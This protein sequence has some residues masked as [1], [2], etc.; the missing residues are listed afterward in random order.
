MEIQEKAKQS[1]FYITLLI[2]SLIA[3]VFWL[4]YILQPFFAGLSLND[5]L[6]PNPILLF[7]SIVDFL[8]SLCA[9]TGA[10]IL[11]AGSR[12]GFPFLLASSFFGITNLILYPILF[13]KKFQDLYWQNI[14]DMFFS[15]A[16]ALIFFR[17]L[18]G[19]ESRNS[20]IALK[21]T[22]SAVS[23]VISFVY[24]FILNRA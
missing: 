8:V 23:S 24:L 13:I 21:I 6:Y 3:G 1:G 17:L 10:I 20:S 19:K 14:L 11:L 18:F 5:L 22:L 15:L 7:N 12:K 4:Y 2:I 9:I 16:M